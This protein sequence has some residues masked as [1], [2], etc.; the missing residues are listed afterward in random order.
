VASLPARLASAPP[1]PR[2]AAAPAEAAQPAAAVAVTAPAAAEAP[3]AATDDDE[4][5]F[6]EAFVDTPLCTS[7]N[8][9]IQLNPAMF[10]Y[11]ADKQATLADVKAG[12]FA[13]L[14]IAA[15]KCTAKCIF[16][17]APRAGDATATPE[18]VAR[19]KAIH[20]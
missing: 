1:A 9:C 6:D 3:P 10:K 8:E 16:P 19:A 7:C 15:E 13:Q 20:A 11:N 14:V 2:P 12:T 4:G 17:G 18:L 5:G